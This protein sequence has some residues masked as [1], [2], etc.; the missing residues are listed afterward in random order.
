MPLLSS[1]ALIGYYPFEGNGNDLSGNGNTASIGSG[2]TFET[3]TPFGIGTAVRSNATNSQNLVQVATSPTLES[4]SD[5]LTL[6]FWANIDKAESTDDWFRLFQHGT[7][8]GGDRSW[9]VTRN[10]LDEDLLIRI[11]TDP[12]E[13]GA[14]NQNLA[15]GAGLGVLD[16][17]WHHHAYV[18]D[19][20]SYA[21]YVDGQ[22]TGSGSYLHGDGFYNSQALKMFGR[23]NRSETIG[24][25]D[26]VALWNTA[27]APHH[28]R[29]LA[30]GQS[31]LGVPEPGSL[32][33]WL[34][35]LTGFL[36]VG[37][38]PRRRRA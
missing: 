29:A 22:L 34:V 18:L 19:N 7:E 14:H 1:A 2:N 6:S 25:L 20:G 26:E 32:A 17:Q 31:A 38:R 12:N 11:D 21:E 15:T 36:A 16:G 30:S 33:L 35:G 3:D 24:M 28:I 10:N 13:G 37:R 23:G 4:I 9:L 27:L 5:K 8:Q